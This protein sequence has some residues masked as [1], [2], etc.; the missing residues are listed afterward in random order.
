[1]MNVE[2]STYISIFLSSWISRFGVAAA[3]TTDRWSQ[4][5]DH[6]WTSFCKKMGIEEITASSRMHSRPSWRTV[7]SLN[8][9][10]RSSSASVWPPKK[11][12]QSLQQN[13]FSDQH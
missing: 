4:F 8:I 6:L 5:P 3:V 9:S 11:T 1:M 13:W 10:T 7:I 12:L 2:A